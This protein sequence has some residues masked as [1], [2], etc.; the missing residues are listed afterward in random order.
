MNKSGKFDHNHTSYGKSNLSLKICRNNSSSALLCFLPCSSLQL[1]HGSIF[2]LVFKGLD[3]KCPSS[4]FLQ[5]STGATPTGRNGLRAVAPADRAS[6]KG[7]DCATTPNQPT[8]AGRAAAP[9]STLGNVKLDSVLVRR[10]C[11]PS[12][13]TAADFHVTGFIRTLHRFPHGRL[14]Y[15]LLAAGSLSHLIF[16]C[17]SINSFLVTKQQEN[18]NSFFFHVGCEIFPFFNGIFRRKVWRLP[19]GGLFI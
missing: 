2:S 4:V 6:K 3:S 11:L 18:S 16:L 19:N 9:A 10:A 12:L 5:Q 8:E 13:S 14:G 1:R 7:S 17:T 15:R